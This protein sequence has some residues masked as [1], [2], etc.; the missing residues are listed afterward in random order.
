MSQSLGAGHFLTK[1]TVT[2][3]GE[4]FST[5]SVDYDAVTGRATKLT[6]EYPSGYAVTETYTYGDDNALTE[7]TRTSGDMSVKYAVSAPEGSEVGD[8]V[9][10]KWTETPPAEEENT[11]RTRE[12]TLTLTDD[13]TVLLRTEQVITGIGGTETTEAD[14]GA[15]KLVASYQ[16]DN[17]P[18]ADVEGGETTSYGFT[19]A[20]DG[21]T[22]SVEQEGA[23]LAWKLAFD[24]DGCLIA[25]DDTAGTVSAT[26]EYAGF[27]D[28][29]NLAHFENQNRLMQAMFEA[30]SATAN[31]AGSTPA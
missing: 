18:A 15:N 14:F 19:F 5:T 26:F 11:E 10:Y 4:T 16:V 24:E 20:Y 25:M 2:V 17:E 6:T 3:R 28:P 29:V 27:D 31:N 13:A 21:D 12:T 8:D 30:V 23:S 22:M 7:V 1:A 9:T